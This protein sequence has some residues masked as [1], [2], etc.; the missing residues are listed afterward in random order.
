MNVGNPYAVVLLLYVERLVNVSSFSGKGC[1]EMHQKELQKWVESLS[2]YWFGLPFKHEARFNA[3]LRTTGGRYL[4]GSHDI[5]FNPKQLDYYGDDE[6][7]KI[8][9]HELCHYH[10]HLQGRGYQHRDRDFKEL[11]KKV[12]G[13]RHCQVIPGTRNQQRIRHSYR[14]RECGQLYERKR[15]VDT[16]R[17]VCGKCNGRLKKIR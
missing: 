5:E 1:C 16:R 4:L 14:C 8:I 10:L 2:G 11:L 7:E 12:G 3:R 13:S 9:K 15:R 17:F 6:F